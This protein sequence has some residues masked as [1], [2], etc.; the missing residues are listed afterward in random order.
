MMMMMIG[1]II[2]MIRR[3]MAA[4]IDP[5]A[6]MVLIII[7]HDDGED[8]Y[9]ARPDGARRHHASGRPGR[10]PSG[11]RFAA[12]SLTEQFGV[13]RRKIEDDVLGGLTMRIIRTNREHAP[14]FGGRTG[15]RLTLRKLGYNRT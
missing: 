12:E 1:T 7:V 9:R 4:T 15:L 13:G 3:I 8:G 5:V 10:D 14:V 2:G 6:T 11:R